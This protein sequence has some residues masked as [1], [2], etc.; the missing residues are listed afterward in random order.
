MPSLCSLLSAGW[1]ACSSCFG[2]KSGKARKYLVTPALASSRVY[3]EPH[4]SSWPFF[5]GPSATVA[6]TRLLP[7]QAACASKAH[8]ML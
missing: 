2:D 3:G 6:G 4:G 5:S 1:N 7:A 8:L